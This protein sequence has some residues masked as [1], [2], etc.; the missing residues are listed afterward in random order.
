M[1]LNLRG[2]FYAIYR[3]WFTLLKIQNV[4]TKLYWL[5]NQYITDKKMVYAFLSVNHLLRQ[6]T[7][8]QT[9]LAT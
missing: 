8:S 7:L 2:I 4:S 6:S 3:L 9:P 5:D 1:P